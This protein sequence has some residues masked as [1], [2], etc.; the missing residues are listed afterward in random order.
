MGTGEVTPVGGVTEEDLVEYGGEEER[1]D[2]DGGVGES[3]TLFDD[4]VAEELL[5]MF[6]AES[7]DVFSGPDSLKTSVLVH[8]LLVPEEPLPVLIALNLELM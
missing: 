7:L 8:E 5:V 4:A 6:D 3:G 2:T 1:F